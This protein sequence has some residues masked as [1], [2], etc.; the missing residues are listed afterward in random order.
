MAGS[1]GRDNWAAM[2]RGFG[3][4]V[5]PDFNIAAACCRRWAEAADGAQRV[6]IRV[7]G[8]AGEATLTFAQMQ[9]EADAM[10]RLLASLGV[11]RGD[12]VAIVMPQRFETAIAYLAVFQLGAVAMPLSI[13]FGPEALEYRCRT[14]PRASRSATKARWPTSRRCA[15]SVRNCAPWSAWVA[16]ARRPTST[17]RRSARSLKARSHRCL[18]RLGTR[19]S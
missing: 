18:R 7:H 9:R 11:R 13:L 19:P 6:A 14:A 3:W 2:H 15:R 17:G 8:E 1:Q 4:H 12:R 16:P 5:P 10:S